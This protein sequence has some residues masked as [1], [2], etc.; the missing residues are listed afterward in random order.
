MDMQAE[1]FL[2]KILVK[3]AGEFSLSR[4]QLKI[5][6]GFLTEHCHLKGHLYNWGL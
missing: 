5:I 6:I 1:G 3:E 4:N 2:Q